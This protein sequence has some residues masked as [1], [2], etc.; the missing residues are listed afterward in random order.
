M[1]VFCE[2]KELM[3]DGSTWKIGISNYKQ[4][5]IDCNSSYHE[6]ITLDINYCPMC[7]KKL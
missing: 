5:E 4:I 7:G 6:E 3:W 1:C 2:G